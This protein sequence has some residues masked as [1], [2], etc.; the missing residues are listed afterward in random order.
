MR[1]KTI[2]LLAIAFGLGAA[3][4]ASAAD[5]P[6]RMPAKAPMIAPAPVFSWTGCYIG[7][8]VGGKWA[9]TS[10]SVDVPASTGLAGPTPAGSVPFGS[11]GNNNGTFV[12]GGQI[13]CNYQ[14]GQVVFGV[15]GDADWQHFDVTRTVGV[16]PPAPFVAGDSFN[17]SSRWQASFR[18]RIGYAWD[19]TLLYATGGVAFT[20]LKT[21]SNWIAVGIFPATVASDSATLVGATFGGGLEYA[22]WQNLSLGVEGRYTWYGNHTFNAGVLSTAVIPGVAPVFTTAPTTQTIKLST[23]EVLLKLNYRFGGF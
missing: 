17:A 11:D 4:A 22:F 18:G 12:G 8:N 2:T 13:G 14:T 23:A 16:A 1:S 10:G 9:R 19:R 3:Q 7:G 6:A 21:G 20:E 5:M 15:E